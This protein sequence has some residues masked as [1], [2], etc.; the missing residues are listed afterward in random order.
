MFFLIFVHEITQFKVLSHKCDIIHVMFGVKL[1]QK[2]IIC[3]LF[4][5]LF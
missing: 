4:T 2:N 1:S 5:Y 3:M